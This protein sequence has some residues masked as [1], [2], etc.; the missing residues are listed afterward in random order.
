MLQ[1]NLYKRWGGEEIETQYY[2]KTFSVQNKQMYKMCKEILT[3][4]HSSRTGRHKKRIKLGFANGDE[5]HLW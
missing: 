5:C 1:L 4:N 3:D 2:Q